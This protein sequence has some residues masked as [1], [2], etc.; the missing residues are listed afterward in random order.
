MVC[1]ATYKRNGDLRSLL[2]SIFDTSPKPPSI[3]IVDN[4]PDGGAR[5]LVF[6]EFPGTRYIHEAVP[7]I[8]AARNAALN[9]ISP[10]ADAAIFVDDDERVCEGWL[11][12]LIE[13]ANE[14]GA[15]VV[16]GPVNSILPEGTPSWVVQG[17]FIQREYFKTGPYPN[18]PA[19]NNTLVRASWVRGPNGLRFDEAFSLTGG[20]DT[21]FFNRARSHGALIH[22]CAEAVV[23][24]NVPTNRL[25]VKWIW[26]RGVRSGNVLAR[27]QLQ[28]K[29]A[30]R[31]VVAGILRF[32][33]GSIRVIW[34]AILLRPLRYADTI[35]LMRGVGFVNAAIG[36]LH[37]EYARPNSTGEEKR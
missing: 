10:E 24:E 6:N 11:V 28:S 37:V 7:G 33:Y 23:E 29:T 30:A 15:D 31:V 35:Y 16:T 22:W 12:S 21:E 32:G 4:D 5:D 34:N 26:N 36:R 2:Q 20:S 13:Y 18:L 19:T 1:V 8:A 9:A 27:I 3:I 17:S 25:T 14:S